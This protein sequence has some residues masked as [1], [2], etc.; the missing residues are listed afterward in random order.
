VASIVG[1]YLMI[2]LSRTTPA[3][4]PQ[5]PEDAAEDVGSGKPRGCRYWRANSQN[6]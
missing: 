5:N 1:D 3:D 6:D 4:P 2:Q